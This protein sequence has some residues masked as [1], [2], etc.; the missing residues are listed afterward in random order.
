ML[1]ILEGGSGITNIPHKKEI[2]MINFLLPPKDLGLG[3]VLEAKAKESLCSDAS[4][5]Y[6]TVNSYEILE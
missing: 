1:E 2:L 3:N 6:Y 5:T 4:K